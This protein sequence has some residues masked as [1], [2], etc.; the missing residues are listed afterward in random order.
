M[1]RQLYSSIIVAGG[2]TLFPGF[3]ERL[4]NDLRSL[5]PDGCKVNIYEMTDPLTS[6]WKGLKHFCSNKHN[7]EDFV[8]TRKEY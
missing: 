3:K 6:A 2:N 7:F 4:E 5:K 1:E 8:V